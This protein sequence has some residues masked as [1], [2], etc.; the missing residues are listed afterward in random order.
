MRG[1]E[2][3]SPWDLKTQIHDQAYGLDR[4]CAQSLWIGPR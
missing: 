3:S 4:Q 1:L 2:H